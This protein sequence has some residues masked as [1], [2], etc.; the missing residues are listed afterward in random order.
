VMKAL[1]A[2]A[3]R[4]HAAGN[5]IGTLAGTPE[6]AAQVRAAGYDFVGLGTDLGLLVRAAQASLAALRSADSTLVHSLS[7]GTH[8][9]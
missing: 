1:I 9:Y 6:M 3:A 4:A 5:P 2:A 7:G 8:A